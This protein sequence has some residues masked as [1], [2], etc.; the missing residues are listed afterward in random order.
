MMSAACATIPRFTLG[1]AQYLTNGR[2][3]C[4]TYAWMIEVMI[5]MLADPGDGI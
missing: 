4:G 5:A 2:R 1:L 3:S